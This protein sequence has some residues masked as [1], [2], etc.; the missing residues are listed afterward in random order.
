M[1]RQAQ[2]IIDDLDRA[3]SADGVRP[4]GRE[5]KPDSGWVLLDFGDVIVHLFSPEERV[6]YDLES[7]WHTAT[8]VVRL[9]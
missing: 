9:Q 4:M 5:G 7:L 3:L 6:Y 2:A 1:V 8:Q